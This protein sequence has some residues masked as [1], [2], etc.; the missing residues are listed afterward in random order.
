MPGEV[1]AVPSVALLVN[2]LV[3][4]LIFVLVVRIVMVN[5][6]ALVGRERLG[7]FFGT[8]YDYLTEVT[9]PILAPI[10][11]VLPDVAPPLDFSPL[12][13]IIIIDLI[14]RLLIYLLLRVL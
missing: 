8:I 3:V 13:A 1:A 12:V 11:R 10:R 7:R 5:I 4:I 14:G 6:V 2:A 9:D